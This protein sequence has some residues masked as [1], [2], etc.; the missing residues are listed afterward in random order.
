MSKP[1]AM[2]D[3]LVLDGRRGADLV[4][5]NA[6]LRRPGISALREDCGEFDAS[7]MSSIRPLRTRSTLP[8]GGAR[9]HRQEARHLN[10]QDGELDHLP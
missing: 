10:L 9:G 2:F 8:R 3:R 6:T 1:A 7:T 4:E 5:V